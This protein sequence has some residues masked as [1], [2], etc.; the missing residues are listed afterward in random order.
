MHKK[1]QREN[2]IETRKFSNISRFIDD[3]AAINYLARQG[4]WCS[5]LQN[6]RDFIFSC[7]SIIVSIAMDHI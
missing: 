7:S 2:L 3:P 4:H 6:A 5:L 1:D